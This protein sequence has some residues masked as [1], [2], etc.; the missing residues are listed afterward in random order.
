MFRSHQIE[1]VS[2]AFPD[3]RGAVCV[4][5]DNTI[6]MFHERGEEA[7]KL[8]VP[9]LSVATARGGVLYALSGETNDLV[10]TAFEID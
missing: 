8:D 10:L 6:H 4:V 9:N 2:R 7:W 5:A 1:G 3:G